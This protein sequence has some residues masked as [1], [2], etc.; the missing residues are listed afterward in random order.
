MSELQWNRRRDQKGFT[1]LEFLIAVMILS[2]GLLGMA[3]LTG[4]M[5]NY[6]AV[7]YNSTKAVTLAE[8]KMEGLRNLNYQNLS[9]LSSGYDSES[10]F[11]RT[12]TLTP[13]TPD[14]NMIT[15]EVEVT[16]DWKG[17]AANPITLT[18]IVGE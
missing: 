14:D 7:A 2:I 9:S 11:T 3:T 10:I 17:A 18:S 4:A 5:I 1:L 8:E 12:W 15:I 13:D 6:N 16:W